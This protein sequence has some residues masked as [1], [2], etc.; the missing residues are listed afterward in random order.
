MEH[1][2]SYKILLFTY[3]ALND[4]VPQYLT[5]L[6]S[7]YVAPRPSFRMINISSVR[8]DDGLNHFPDPSEPS[9][10]HDEASSIDWLLQ[11][12]T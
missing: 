11:D 3:K 6:I 12:Q 2:I 10:A 5:A 7:K 4:H 8:Q 9:T 1:R